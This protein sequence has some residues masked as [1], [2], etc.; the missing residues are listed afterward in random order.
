MAE[1]VY[2]NFFGDIPCNTAQ[3][4]E[5]QVLFDFICPK[6]CQYFND[7]LYATGNTML[8]AN[9]SF[10]GSTNIP[11]IQ[12]QLISYVNMVVQFFNISQFQAIGVLYEQC[13]TSQY[14]YYQ[15]GCKVR[16]N[17]SV[18]WE[19]I[20]GQMPS[21]EAGLNAPLIQVTTTLSSNNLVNQSLV[22]NVIT[23]TNVTIDQDLN[24]NRD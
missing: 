8:S 6:L 16:P 7:Y 5:Q 18:I 21:N 23:N 14:A 24:I 22:G 15:V 10:S 2:D 1:I 11:A 9:A 12:N 17:T 13:A 4:N 20:L 19:E 3:V